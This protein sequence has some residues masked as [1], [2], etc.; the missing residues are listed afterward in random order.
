LET[1]TTLTWWWNPLLWW[2]RRELRRVEEEA[3]DERVLV[4]RPH[5]GPDY[6]A[7]L[8]NTVGG[9]AGLFRSALVCEAGEIR[10][11][12]RR[13]SMILAFD[14]KPRCRSRLAPA[15]AVTAALLLV[16]LTP[17]LSRAQTP[18]TAPTPPLPPSGPDPFG[19]RPDKSAPNA[20]RPGALAP[21]TAENVPPAGGLPR[22]HLTDR[23]APPPAVKPVPA[24]PPGP[25]VPSGRLPIEFLPPYTPVE[26][27]IE[28]ELERTISVNLDNTPVSDAIEFLSSEIGVTIILDPAAVK[29]LQIER[30][31]PMTLKVEKIQFAS[32]LRRLLA[33]LH[34]TYQIEDEVLL[35]TSEKLG[36]GLVT[37]TYPVGDLVGPNLVRES[38]LPPP[39]VSGA[40][41]DGSRVRRAARSV[42]RF[43]G[44]SLTA[45][46]L[47]QPPAADP[48]LSVTPPLGTGGAA[49]PAGGSGSMAPGGSKRPGGSGSVPGLS[50]G[51]GMGIPAVDVGGS[52][53]SGRGSMAAGGMSGTMGGGM[54]MGGGG[55]AVRLPVESSGHPGYDNLVRCLRGTTDPGVW[56]EQGGG[57]S[58][59]AMP[60]AG[61]I[62]VRASRSTHAEILRTLRSLRAAMAVQRTTPATLPA[63]VTPFTG[64]MGAAEA[65]V[66]GMMLPPPK[67]PQ[68][69]PPGLVPPP[70]LTPAEGPLGG[71]IPAG[72]TTGG[73]ALGGSAPGGSETGDSRPEL[74]DLGISGS[75]SPSVPTPGLSP[76]SPTGAVPTTPP[77]DLPKVP[78]SA[79]K[80]NPGPAP[81]PAAPVRRT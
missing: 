39:S 74:P 22:T 2:A 60:S 3:C 67:R 7:L 78:G 49:A 41:M 15:L 25:P 68:P 16:P 17:Q 5:A 4:R 47:R 13:V 76:P 34:L 20:A 80:G 1:L 66:P 35:L 50:G 36:G 57:G 61:S 44:E 79:P 28:Q 29:E 58:I 81:G 51:A 45:V 32:V 70:G 71:S 52:T 19:G 30:D 63:N 12:S 64:D 9:R 18:G 53:D 27:R 21:P 72:S 6:A 24:A 37:R 54:M 11:L 40:G 23:V 55:G 31:T 73:S 46:R 59:I 56:V 65:P 26:K 69:V 75:L 14:G 77:G 10:N 43:L 62:V 42:D 8:V 33:Q 38:F 48:R